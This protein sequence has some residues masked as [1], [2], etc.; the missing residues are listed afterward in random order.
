MIKVG[1]VGAAGRMGRML[2]SAVNESEKMELAGASEAEGNSF[3]GFDAGELAGV[4][5]LGVLISDNLEDLFEKAD[6]II[7]F[8]AP[9][10]TVKNAALAAKHKKALIIGTTGLS[11]DEQSI[12]DEASKQTVI[13]Q[14][15][16]MSVGVNLLFALVE[17][18]SSILD[19]D[20]D[21]EIF[22]AHHNKKK[23][24]PSGTAVGLGKAAAKGRGVSLDDVGVLSRE[25]IVGEREKG[26]IG[27]STMR[28][29]NIV[30]EHT[31]FYVGGEE[32]IEIS[33]KANSRKIF[34]NGAIKAVIWSENKSSG[35][36]S[37][38]DVLG[39]TDL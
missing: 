30:G 3:V 5:K 15:P 11:K 29:G 35:L 4:G 19:D 31:V 17:K 28:G 34:A 2:V 23:D 25:G 6:A 8:T 20:F 39:L 9:V 16:N 18:V 26:E 36:Y 24:A 10:V 1:V 14:A 21:I 38:I 27:F 22:E 7:D 32:R 13:I 33:H 12:I 37:M